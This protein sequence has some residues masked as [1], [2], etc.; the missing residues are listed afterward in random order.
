MVAHPFSHGI[1]QGL[2]SM[3]LEDGAK[4]LEGTAGNCGVSAG[5][6]LFVPC[7]GVCGVNPPFY[8]TVD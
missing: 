3:L 8:Y 1:G 5:L 4:A 2:G 7:I 6:N